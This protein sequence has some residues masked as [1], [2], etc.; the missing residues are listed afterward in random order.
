MKQIWVFIRNVGKNEKGT[1]PALWLPHGLAIVATAILSANANGDLDTQ[2]IDKSIGAKGNLIEAEGVYKIAFPRD[3]V[4]ISVDGRR[5]EPFLGLTSWAAFKSGVATECM[6]MGDLVLLEDEVSAAMDACLQAGIE[7]TA[8]HNHFFFD[9]P[10]VYFMHIGGE[11][12]I[13]KFATGVRRAIDAAKLIRTKS[14]APVRSFGLSA[15]PTANTISAR[16]LD[17]VFGIQGTSKDGMYKAVFGRTVKMSCGCEVGKEMGVN[18]WAA[19]AGSDEFALVDG[20]FA[21]LEDE[22]QQVLKLL[23]KS[24]IHVVAIHHHM[25]S[26]SPR[27]LFLHYW[28]VGK[29]IDLARGVK[30]ALAAQLAFG[31]GD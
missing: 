4:S 9:E 8:L 19:F 1:I 3:D 7:V 22:L 28:G 15:V 18:T 6:I 24:G 14:P 23:R 5:M 2:K 31:K 20:D 16:Q 17:E 11:G 10:K 25:I 12:P 29:A 26:E 21:V 27:M 13:D 30:S